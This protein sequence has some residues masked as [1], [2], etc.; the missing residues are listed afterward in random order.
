MPKRDKNREMEERLARIEDGL[1]RSEIDYAI[2]QLGDRLTVYNFDPSKTVESLSLYQSA[3]AMDKRAAIQNG[4]FAGRLEGLYS[5]IQSAFKDYQERK[6]KEATIDKLAQ[7]A[8]EGDTIERMFYYGNF[9]R[10]YRTEE[11]RRLDMEY[12]QAL[13]DR[14]RGLQLVTSTL[15]HFFED[16]ADARGYFAG[17]RVDE[18]RNFVTASTLEDHLTNGFV[19]L[20]KCP[21]DGMTIT[22]PLRFS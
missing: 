3:S 5:K 9:S 19:A 15:M 12:K 7:Q 13:A 6:V 20:K 1:A 14:G 18:L 22:I 11:T 8:P 16:I 21:T 17:V 2:Q 10:I 4:G